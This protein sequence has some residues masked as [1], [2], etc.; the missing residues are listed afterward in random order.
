[1]GSG[2]RGGQGMGSGHRGGQGM[3]SGHWGGQ[4]MGSGHWG[5]QGMGSGH[6]GRSG[7]WGQDMWG[8]D[9]VWDQDIGVV[10]H[11]GSGHR[12]V[13]HMVMVSQGYGSGQ[14]YR[15]CRDMVVDRDMGTGL[16]GW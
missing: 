1:M 9:R 13:R 10:K 4:G 11:M 16:Q 3:G 14:S 7:I 2:H 15:G 6:M 5:G 8:Q 12:E